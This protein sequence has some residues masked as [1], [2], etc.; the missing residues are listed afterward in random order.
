MEDRIT[1]YLEA[2]HSGLLAGLLVGSRAEITPEVR[3]QFAQTGT[4]HIVAVSGFN[5]VIV[6]GFVLA[7]APRFLGVRGSSLVAILAVIAYTLVVGAPASA[8]RAAIMAGFALAARIAGRPTDAFNGLLAAG[9]GMAVVDPL[10]LQDLGFQLSM[11]ATAGLIL[12]TPP[13]ET[14]RT[15]RERLTHAAVAPLA[16]QAATLP[17]VLQVFHSLSLVA[18]AANMVVAPL[19]PV[20]M[21]A[22]G[23]LILVAD[24]EP[25][26]I[27]ASWLAWFAAAGI[28]EPVR[29][30]ATL[31]GAWMATGAFPVA[32]MLGSYLAMLLWVVQRSSELHHA[33]RVRTLLRTAAPFVFAVSVLSLWSPPR[34]SGQLSG[35]LLDSGELM[36]ASSPSGKMIVVGTEVSPQ[37]LVATVAERLPFWKR[38]IDVVIVNENSPASWRGVQALTERYSVDVLVTPRSPTIDKRFPGTGQIVEAS[39][40]IRLDLGDD[41]LVTVFPELAE[42]TSR[43]R[44]V[45][46]ALTYGATGLSFPDRAAAA[47]PA[48]REG[49]IT[50]VRDGAAIADSTDARVR[51]HWGRSASQVDSQGALE[52]DPGAFGPIAFASD[53]Y[54]LTIRWSG[55]DGA[56]SDC[57]TVIGVDGRSR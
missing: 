43:S 4:S 19:L 24:L 45:P 26:A 37:V 21:A 17:L 42:T 54:Q 36:V 3:A 52:L 10:V 41:V 47:L 50:V 57:A 53:G 1:T 48:Q 46:L 8:V 51:V 22:G 30:F 32:A 34:S 49:W 56:D 16:A 55:C 20:A 11:L 27:S 2:P 12:F 44:L 23:L 28:L 25:L 6:S 40:E 5:V 18:L 7:V 35:E 39:D 14:A 15:W 13:L 9:A 38:S 31:P 33:P 29:F